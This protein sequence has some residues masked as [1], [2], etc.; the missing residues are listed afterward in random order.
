MWKSTTTQQKRNAHATLLFDNCFP[1]DLL[2]S[3]EAFKS[4][5]AFEM[6][7]DFLWLNPP[8]L[9]QNCTVVE[10]FTLMPGAVVM[11]VPD[12]RPPATEI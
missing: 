5:F 11:P 6:F 8:V 2:A 12:T 4:Q 9:T 7:C 3:M 1:N 10:N